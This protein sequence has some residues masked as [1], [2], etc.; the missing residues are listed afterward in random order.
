MRLPHYW[1]RIFM[2]TE[3]KSR[4]RELVKGFEVSAETCT[5]HDYQNDWYLSKDMYWLVKG[6]WCVPC[7]VLFTILVGWHFV[8]LPSLVLMGR[9][10]LNSCLVW[11]RDHFRVVETWLHEVTFVRCPVFVYFKSFIIIFLLCYKVATV[12]TTHYR[13]EALIKYYNSSDKWTYS[14]WWGSHLN[15]SP[16]ISL[17]YQCFLVFPPPDRLPLLIKE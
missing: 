6:N 15:S 1:C 12:S 11:Q 14:F 17:K 16:Q 7:W 2:P 9:A 5:E 3:A 8:C 13:L 4:L 10:A